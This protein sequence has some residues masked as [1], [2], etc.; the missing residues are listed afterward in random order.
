MTQVE[1]QEILGKP[2]FVLNMS[3]GGRPVVVWVYR[4][5]TL[6]RK[7]ELRLTF[8]YHSGFWLFESGMWQSEP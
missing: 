7:V 5:Y 2:S 1:V 8:T 6:V 3:T 4:W